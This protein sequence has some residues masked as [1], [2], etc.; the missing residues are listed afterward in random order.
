[1]RSKLPPGSIPAPA[2]QAWPQEG[3]R[4]RRRF[5]PHRRLPHAQKKG[6]LYQDLGANHF[7]QILR[8]VNHLQNLGFAVQITPMTA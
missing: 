6:T 1:M 4:R 7:K 3:H 8:L 2:V 5:H